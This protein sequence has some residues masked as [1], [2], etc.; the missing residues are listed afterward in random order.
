ASLQNIVKDHLRVYPDLTNLADKVAIH[1]ND[2]HPALAIPELMRLLMDEYGF[3]YDAA[4][5]MTVAATAYTNHTVMAEALETWDERMIADRLPRI[6]QILKEIDRRFCVE[7]DKAY[8]NNAPV[9][10]RMRIIRGGKVRMAPLCVVGSHSVN[11]VS[12]LHSDI[13]KKDLF[14]DFCG[15]FP[16]KFTNV[17][18]GIAHRRWLCQ[19]NPGLTD[20]IKSLIGDGFVSDASE[21]KKLEAYADDPQALGK[22]DQIK[23]ANKLHYAAAAAADGAVLDP[24]SRFDVQIKRLH[25][26]K[27]QLLNV[28]RIIS[29]F[30][31]VCD[32]AEIYPQTF[33]FGA[34]AAPSYYHAKRVISLIN[35][36]GAEIRRD[37]RA[38]K[39]L[40]VHFAENY[41]VSVAELLLP[42][43][44]VSQQISLAGKEA[45]GT[46][47]MKFMLNG[48][49][50]LGTLDGANVEICEAVGRNNCFIF[51]MSARDAAELWRKGY[52]ATYYYARDMRLKRAVEFLKTGL[53]GEF[54]DIAAYL[55]TASMPDPYMCMADFPDYM[56]AHA[57]LD[58]AYRDRARFS[59]MSL[60]NIAE[61]GRFA[62]DRSI[63]E[64][65]ENIWGLKPVAFYP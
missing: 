35:A 31:D 38:K 61:A 4:W 22:L 59:G 11:G 5:A 62:A 64:Y 46:S 14:T 29:L 47:N 25:E 45:S 12:Q 23:R 40:T 30:E 34:K 53:G 3:G 41:N 15:M 37:T 65:A 32:G 44:E 58:E 51:G 28:L 24:D 55:T 49:V 56:R 10:D 27:R 17:T 57:A 60:V 8:P 26:Y 1:I 43:S 50:T 7:A 39:Y 20:L 9:L 13:I 54:S 6:H 18:N 42:A 2:T 21:L 36:L 48:A 33:I 19:C 52:Y 63:R 16:G